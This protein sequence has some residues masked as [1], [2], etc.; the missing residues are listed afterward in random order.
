MIELIIA[1]AALSGV[2][3]IWGWCLAGNR[4]THGDTILIGGD[5]IAN[6]SP[7]PTGKGLLFVEQKTQT[8]LGS[9]L[10]VYNGDGDVVG[11]WVAIFGDEKNCR[12]ATLDEARLQITNRLRA[13]YHY[14]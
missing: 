7:S 10:P 6:V 4:Q 13:I 14:Q 9:I 5:L 1:I 8:F 12:C 2:V 3:A 11:Y